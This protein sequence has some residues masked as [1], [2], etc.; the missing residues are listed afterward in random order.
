MNESVTEVFL[1]QPLA[2]PGSAKYYSR[3]NKEKKKGGMRRTCVKIVSR[4]ISR[5][6]EGRA[7]TMMV[8]SF[9]PSFTL[10][11]HILATGLHA[12]QW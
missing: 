7:I 10:S 4:K 11:K 9:N 12:I 1:E 8:V 2:L 6:F 5:M 3:S